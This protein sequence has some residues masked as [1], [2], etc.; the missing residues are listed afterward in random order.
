MLFFAAKAGCGQDRAEAG[1]A[2]QRRARTSL[3][4]ARPDEVLRREPDSGAWLAKHA[5]LAVRGAQE[6]ADRS[7]AWSRRRR[8]AE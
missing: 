1:A 5:E 4:A 7:S 8:A 3:R 2:H 6:L